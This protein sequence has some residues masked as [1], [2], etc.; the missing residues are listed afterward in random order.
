VLD[1]AESKASLEPKAT[2]VI[3]PDDLHGLFST[4]PDLAGGFT[5]IAPYVRQ[6]DRNVDVLVYWREFERIPPADLL[7]AGR[8]ETVSVPFYDV[9]HFMKSRKGHP[10][11]WDEEAGSWVG[12]ALD[13]IVAG[14]TILLPISA[15]GY[16]TTKG[17]TGDPEDKPP[18]L[19]A[20]GEGH[21]SLFSEHESEISW[22][23]LQEHTSAVDRAARDLAVTLNLPG[24]VQQVFSYAAHWHDVGKAHARWQEPLVSEAPRR[25]GS[26]WGKFKGVGVFRP[27]FRHEA[28]SLLAAWEQWQE[29]T[30][31]AAALAL[32]LVASHHGKVRTVLRA[33]GNGDDLFGLVDADGPLEWPGYLRHPTRIDTSRKSFAGRGIFN[34]AERTYSPKEPSWVAIVEELLGPAWHEDL[35]TVEAVPQSEPRNLGPFKLAYFEGVFR[36]ADARASRGDFTP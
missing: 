26:L 16:S 9:R 4:E 20:L 30:Q 2:T 7:E 21:C 23:T 22:Q 14:M 5:N 18:L 29:H 34:W 13:E 8:E 11:F 28:L 35:V 1:S 32:Y 17:W 6:D 27:G 3:R 12:L 24:P 25:D 15:G 33:T 10:F 19:P 36:A 31:E